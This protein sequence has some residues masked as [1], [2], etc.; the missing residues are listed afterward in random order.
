LL[1]YLMRSR[2]SVRSRD[3][4]LEQVWGDLDEAGTNLVEV[5]VGYLRKKLDQPFGTHSLRTV[6]G[7]GYQLD[8]P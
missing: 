8:D 6:R 3:E 4:I 1:E 7:Q 5:Y 2:G